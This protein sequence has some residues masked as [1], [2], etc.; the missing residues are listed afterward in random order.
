MKEAAE[1]LQ[2]PPREE[3]VSFVLEYTRTR[4]GGEGGATN[5]N[6]HDLREN[7]PSQREQRLHAC[8]YRLRS[9]FH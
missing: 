7:T 6:T 8:N 1:P 2:L 9:V 3:N 4:K 5:N